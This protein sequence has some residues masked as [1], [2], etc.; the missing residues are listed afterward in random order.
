MSFFAQSL[1]LGTCALL[2]VLAAIGLTALASP[3]YFSRI[4][5]RGGEWIDTQK[6][7]E[8]LDKRIDIDE[9]VLPYSRVLGFA[10]LASVILIASLLLRA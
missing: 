5:R 10:V 8:V 9:T 4:A 6:V 2:G 7:V 3:T 1:S